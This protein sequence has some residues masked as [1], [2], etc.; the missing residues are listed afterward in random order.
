MI[1]IR[2]CA[3]CDKY[4]GYMEYPSDEPV[5]VSHGIC[6]EC[7]KREYREIDGLG[8]V[9]LASPEQIKAGKAEELALFAP[10]GGDA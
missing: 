5:M 2:V 10:E 8:M 4:L 7:A 1:L 3:W 6:P 9:Q